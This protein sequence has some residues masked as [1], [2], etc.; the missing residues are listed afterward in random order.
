MRTPLPYSLNGPPSYG[1]RQHRP[2]A[3]T[4]RQGGMPLKQYPMTQGSEFSRARR[5]F[6]AEKTWGW[7]GPKP[8]PCMRGS[9]TGSRGV[10]SRGNPTGRNFNCVSTRPLV[11][12]YAYKAKATLLAQA[13]GS[14]Y[15]ARK[16]MRAIG[17][18]SSINHIVN[19]GVDRLSFRAYDQNVPNRHRQRA[20]S[21]GS[22]AP[23]KKGQPT[24]ACCTTSGPRPRGRT[25]GGGCCGGGSARTSY[26]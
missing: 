6:E 7:D 13:S 19:P 23:K 18:S 1:T 20:R 12:E 17:K 25:G 2:N 21:G 16:K 24:A 26:I 3:Y 11:N 22:V 5:V 15:T 9:I 4:D 10:I 8:G 14:D